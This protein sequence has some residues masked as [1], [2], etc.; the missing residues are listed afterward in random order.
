MHNERPQSNAKSQTSIFLPVVCTTASFALVQAVIWLYP[1]LEAPQRLNWFQLSGVLSAIPLFIWA[2][3]QFKSG[4]RPMVP[5]A[6]GVAM[7]LATWSSVVQDGFSGDAKPMYVWRWQKAS[8]VAVT[9]PPATAI[10]KSVSMNSQTKAAPTSTTYAVDEALDYPGFL[11]RDRQ[12]HVDHVRLAEN[13]DTESPREIWRVPV[14]SGWSSFALVGNRAVTQEQH[15]ADEAIVCRDLK[16]GNTIWTSLAQGERFSETYGGEGPR[17]TPTV[18][19]NRVYALGATGILKC[20]DLQSGEPMWQRN[21]LQDA[22]AKNLEWGMAGSPLVFDDKVVV[23]PGGKNNHSIV[24]YQRET[25]EVLWHAG[26]GRAAYSSP[27]LVEIAGVQQVVLLNGPGLEGY[28]ATDGTLLWSHA[29]T[30]NGAMM[31]SVTQPLVIPGDEPNEKQFFLSGGYGK[32]CGLV[33]VWFDGQDFHASEV[34]EPTRSLKSKFNNMLHHEG[35]VYGFDDKVLTC[36]DLSDGSRRWK[37]GRYGY[38]QLLLANDLIV[39]QEESGSVTLVRA[40]PEGHEELGSFEP[41]SR[42][43]WNPPAVRGNRL[44][45]RNDREA[46]CVELPIAADNI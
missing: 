45:I 8:N 22:D 10:T 9:T 7:A 14:G 30:V 17:A 43:T 42:K 33:R 19:G 27:M 41:L 35:F 12:A 36:V 29:W 1:S 46:V 20:L 16:T 40:T 5:V 32:G 44:V 23:C 31:T 25:G 18:A 26:S 37:K 3:T 39:V 13:W 6:V 2:H 21:I 34:W 11:G 24:A 4:A 15:G 38:G 28:Q